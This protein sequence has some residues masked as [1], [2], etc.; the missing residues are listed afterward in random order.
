MWWL[1]TAGISS[2][3]VLEAGSPKSWCWQSYVPSKSSREESF[4]VCVP[5]PAPV[6]W[7]L[8]LRPHCSSLCLCL[9]IAFSSVCVSICTQSPHFIALIKN[10]N[11][12]SASLVDVTCL[13]PNEFA[14][15]QPKMCLS[16]LCLWSRTPLSPGGREQAW[17]PHF[18][19][20]PQIKQTSIPQK[21]IVT[22]LFSFL[23][24]FHLQNIFTP[25]PALCWV[26][27][28]WEAQIGRLSSLEARGL[29]AVNN[30][31]VVF[32]ILFFFLIFFYWV[33]NRLQSC[34]I[35]IVH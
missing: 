11:H 2:L 17:D 1:W 4:F 32:E 16:S 24:S 33:I 22:I 14:A 9:H 5:L 29:A 25:C 23:P 13:S 26:L 18:T 30:F 35:S 27:G 28:P 21:K 10:Y 15:L 6:L 34:E 12:F 31:A 7:F 19:F 3:T 8:D 20:L